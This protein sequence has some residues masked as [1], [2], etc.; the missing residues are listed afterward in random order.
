MGWRRAAAALS[1]FLGLS[2]IDTED[3]ISGLAELPVEVLKKGEGEIRSSTGKRFFVRSS[4]KKKIT[5][6]FNAENV[7]FEDVSSFSNLQVVQTWF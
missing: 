1:S 3:S 4:N 7:V 2:M 6:T 5:T